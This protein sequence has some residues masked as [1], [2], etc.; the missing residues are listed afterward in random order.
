M[1]RK[2]ARQAADGGQVFHH[3]YYA[4][5]ENANLDIDLRISALMRG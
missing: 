1:G 4:P 2:V 5:T 3:G